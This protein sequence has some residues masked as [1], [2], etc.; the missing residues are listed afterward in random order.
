MPQ[1]RPDFNRIADRSTDGY[2]RDLF[3]AGLVFANLGFAALAGRSIAALLDP[4]L[5]LLELVPSDG[6]QE[7]QALIDQMFRTEAGEARAVVQF[8]RPDGSQ[9]WVELFLVAVVDKND[10]VAGVDGLVRDVSEYLAVADSLSRRSNEQSALLKAQRDLLT[11]LDVDESVDSIVGRACDLLAARAV[12]LFLLEPDGEQLRPSATIGEPVPGPLQQDIQ[13]GR[14]VMGWLA[15]RGEPLRIDRLT[16]DERIE[17]GSD[18]VDDECS[19]LSA[20]LVLADR[21]VGVLMVIGDPDQYRDGDLRFLKALA[22]VAS[23]SLANSRSYQAVEQMA[24]RDGLTG[25]FNRHFLEQNL[26]IELERAARMGYPV[27]VLMLD[28]DDLKQINDR[29]GHPAGDEVLRQL[30]TSTTSVIRETDW[31]A[32]YGGDEFVVVA[33][34]CPREHLAQLCNKIQAAFEAAP[35]IDGGQEVAAYLSIGAGA[36]AVGS[37]DAEALIRAVDQAERSAKAQG[38]DQFQIQEF[39]QD[40]QTPRPGSEGV[41]VG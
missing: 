26:P 23:L 19:L 31:I 33:P 4:P 39:A 12:S 24:T 37:L 10:Q 1:N 41:D 11:T 30:V 8:Q 40:Q 16:T 18:W 2:F 5:S 7:L 29:H 3:A 17:S 13:V 22:Q 34:G 25:A 32:R 36:S 20:P 38:G 6:Q 27:S 28:I 35:A 9:I 21:V 14:G 15:E